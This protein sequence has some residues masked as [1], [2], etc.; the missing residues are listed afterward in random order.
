MERTD[1]K[2]HGLTARE[3]GLV[4]CTSC[5]LV[6]P[7]ADLICARCNTRLESRSPQ[8]LQRVWAWMAAGLLLYIPANLYPMLLTST[9]GDA[10]QS[11]IIGGVIELVHHHSYGIA[12]IVF[13]ASIVIPV[14]KFMAVAFLAISIKRPALLDGHRRLVLYEVV[15][16]IGRWSMIDVF[17]VAILSALVQLNF[18]ATVNPGPAAACFALSVAFTM[19][20]AQS[21]DSRLIWDVSNEDDV[22]E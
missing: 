18:V 22:H 20:S 15:E 3:A 21:F 10:T 6:H 9:L 14:M 12:A 4:A 17:V 2:A 16:F 13:I 7:P 19:L 8:S 11:T 1:Q 5:G